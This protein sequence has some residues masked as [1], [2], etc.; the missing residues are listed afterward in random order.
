MTA[1][2]AKTQPK[3][4]YSHIR[5]KTSVKEQVMKMKKGEDGYTEN[6]KEVCDELNKIFQEV[7]TTEQEKVPE[8]RNFV[9]VFM[10]LAALVASAMAAPGGI[11]YGGGYRGGLGGF[12]GGYR[13]GLGGFGG[14]Y[15]GGF[16]GG[17]GGYG[18]GHGGYAGGRANINFNLGHGGGYGGGYGG[19]GLGLGFGRGVGY[20]GGYG[21]YGK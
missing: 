15:G 3:L 14:G 21:G 20:G 8:L 11:G 13:G 6:D 4:L 16:G 12:S 5:R 7:F 10:G 17:Y 18:A 9:Y 19:H 1:N 2:K